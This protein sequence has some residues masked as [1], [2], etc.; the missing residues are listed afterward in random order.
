ML[1]RFQL[2][3]ATACPPDCW[4]CRCVLSRGKYQDTPGRSSCTSHRTCATG[5]T[6]S[7]CR[8]GV[9]GPEHYNSQIL[10]LIGANLASYLVVALERFEGLNILQWGGIPHPL[11]GLPGCHHPHVLHGDDGVQ[12]QL[13]PLLVM[14]SGEPEE[15]RYQTAG[16]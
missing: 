7:A 1:T 3:R 9:V 12:E 15:D 10:T 4:R 16:L 11:Y 6:P 8:N 2:A 5:Y 13:K 14:R